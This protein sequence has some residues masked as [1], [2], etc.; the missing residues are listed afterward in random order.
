MKNGT[1]LSRWRMRQI[2]AALSHATHHGM[3]PGVQGFAKSLEATALMSQGMKKDA[4]VHIK[5]TRRELNEFIGYMTNLHVAKQS[6]L[7]RAR[8]GLA[9]LCMSDKQILGETPEELVAREKT[10]TKSSKDDKVIQL[11][12]KR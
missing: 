5:V 2:V 3:R 12:T 9:V 11:S 8:I 6:L 7:I 1:W 4:A 10:N